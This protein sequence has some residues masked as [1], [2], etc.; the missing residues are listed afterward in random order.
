MKSYHKAVYKPDSQSTDEFICIIGDLE[1]ADP[2]FL[3]NRST[4]MLSPTLASMPA[5][6]DLLSPA[7]STIPLVEIVDS[8]DVFHSGQGS[9]GIL[10]RPSK[11]ELDTV[12]S[13]TNSDAIVET[14]LSKGRIL[15]A[16]TPH[17]YTGKNDQRSGNYQTAQGSVG[18]GG[19]R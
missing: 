16:E 1:G 10:A 14:I 3:F 19:G 15:S 13:T 2:S 5:I 17:Q 4:G 7:R 8:F 9:Q 18:H 12:F 11:Q 6:S